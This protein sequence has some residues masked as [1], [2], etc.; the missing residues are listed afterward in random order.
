M[1][2]SIIPGGRPICPDY[3]PEAENP[4]LISSDPN[5]LQPEH[6]DIIMSELGEQGGTPAAPDYAS[7]PEADECIEG[8]CEEVEE[9]TNEVMEK[10]ESLL[11]SI[12]E[13]ALSTSSSFAPVQSISGFD[14]SALTPAFSTAYTAQA[15]VPN[16]KIAA[17]IVLAQDQYALPDSD[18]Q[19]M[20]C[21]DPLCFFANLQR[22]YAS[23]A[24]IS[25]CKSIWQ[26]LTHRIYLP[27][28]FYSG[29]SCIRNS[30]TKW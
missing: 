6:P 10:L 28:K 14:P 1:G 27:T 3:G 25:S 9:I 23:A 26:Q 20:F 19:D 7:A 22:K 12:I 11:E 17:G 5:P 16:Y 18:E 21:S 8:E 2:A 29:K 15:A 4:S 30:S 13:S 24:I